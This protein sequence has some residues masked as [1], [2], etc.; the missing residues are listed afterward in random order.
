MLQG[1]QQCFRCR[2]ASTVDTAESNE[3]SNEARSH[4]DHKLLEL[5]GGPV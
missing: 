4:D 2:I 5:I 1:I 3:G